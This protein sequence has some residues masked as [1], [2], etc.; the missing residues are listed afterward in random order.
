MCKPWK[1]QG[2][3]GHELK[4]THLVLLERGKFRAEEVA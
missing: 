1:R 4:R 2:C 3:K